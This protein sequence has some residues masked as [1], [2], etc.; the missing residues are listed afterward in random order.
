MER[1][2]V[3]SFN[4]IDWQWPREVIKP[5]YTVLRRRAE[6]VN[7]SEHDFASLQLATLHFDGELEPRELRGKVEFKGKLFFAHA[8][9]VIYSKIDVRNGAIGI[10]PDSMLRVAVSA[11]YPVYQ[12][13]ATLALPDYIK[14]VFR[15]R[16]FR[17]RINAMISGASGRKRVQ[18]D[19]LEE[20]EAPLPPLAGQRAIVERWRSAQAQIAAS[21]ERVE[22][23]KTESSARFLAELGLK[24]PTAGQMPKSLAVHW[25][26]LATWSGSTAFKRLAMGDVHTGGFPVARG[27]D[28]LTGVCHG[29]SAPPSPA[30]TA[31]EILK[32]S[33]VTRGEFV[34]T[35]KKFA[36]DN[37]RVREAI[38]PSE[39]RR[40]PVPHQR[41]ARLRRDVSAR[42]RRRA[43][44]HLPRQSHPRA[45]EAGNYLA[46][47]PVA[48]ATDALLAG[49]N[50]SCGANRRRQLCY[51]RE[52][53]LE[54]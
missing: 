6:T 27:R 5:L 39:R 1:W 50:R 37:P 25:A 34:P 10:V 32:I 3:R 13:D 19:A 36:A 31:L 12:V 22:K 46:R 26:D 51:R 28:F 24:S 44:S 15:T 40:A 16:A 42:P 7:R 14:L 29:C 17:D 18:P 38:R 20:L 11:E 33:A 45:R 9:D 49:A 8:G 21:G 47:L 4:Q 48:G 54:F 41:H 23:L 52:G 2:S 35:E 30:P 53:H 43:E